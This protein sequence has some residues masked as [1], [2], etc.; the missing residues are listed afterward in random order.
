[1]D[2][3]LTQQ[4]G[5]RSQPGPE[6]GTYSVGVAVSKVISN[7]PTRVGLTF[8]NNSANTIW[9]WIT[10]NF[11][12]SQGIFLSANGGVIALNWRDDM[13]LIPNDWYAIASAAASSLQVLEVV[14]R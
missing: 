10:N 1:M 2:D 13:T 7:N 12:A 4:L 3:L 11:G 14:V 6:S 5:V 8:I 9:L